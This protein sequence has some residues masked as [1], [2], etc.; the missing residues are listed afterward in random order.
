M[1]LLTYAAAFAVSVIAPSS[2]FAWGG[3]N[4]RVICGIAWE[5]TTPVART[6]IAEIL[7]LDGRDAFAESCLWADIYRDQGHRETEGWH[8]VNVPPGASAI[9][10]ARDCKE[11]AGCALMRIARDVNIL[12]GTASPEEKAMA[13]K[14]LAHIAGDIH[15]PLHAG[16]AEDRRGGIFKGVFLGQPYDFHWLWDDGLTTALRRPWRDVANELRVKATQAQRRAWLKSVPLD[17]AN[18]SLALANSPGVDYADHG[19]P[20]DLGTDYQ[21]KQLPIIY[22]RLSR[23]GVRLGGLLAQAFDSNVSK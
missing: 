2:A 11:P 20:F 12:K 7:G 22:D 9:D 6:R 13:L 18:E 21:R 10:I 5:E 19:R 3:D 8:Y 23:A 1:R 17:W 4:H 14:F 16:R 15:Q